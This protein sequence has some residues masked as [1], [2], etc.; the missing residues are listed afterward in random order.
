MNNVY[1]GG[2]V[3]MAN[4][5]DSVDSLIITHDLPKFAACIHANDQV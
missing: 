4:S 3:Q 1:T 2:L 5:I